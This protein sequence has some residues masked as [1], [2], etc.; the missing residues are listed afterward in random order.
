VAKGGIVTGGNLKNVASP[1]VN[2]YEVT[3]TVTA[4]GTQL[5]LHSAPLA[6]VNGVSCPV[7]GSCEK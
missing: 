2:W 4:S 3:L 1:R 5:A 7:A 6:Q